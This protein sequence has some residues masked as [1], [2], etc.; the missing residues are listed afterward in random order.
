M[1]LNGQWK[2]QCPMVNEPSG[3]ANPAATAK[4]RPF[5]ERPGFSLERTD[6]SRSECR[7]GERTQSVG[8]A[9]SRPAEIAPCPKR[10]GKTYP[11]PFRG[12][13]AGQREADEPNGYR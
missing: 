1:V 11:N 5:S 9:R 7:K 13:K 3:V 10:E 12:G 2:T 6:S 4:R 8:N